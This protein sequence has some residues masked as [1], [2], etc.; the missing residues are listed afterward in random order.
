MSQ[1]KGE[2]RGKLSDFE[3]GRDWGKKF[4]GKMLA[5]GLGTIESVQQAIE[6]LAPNSDDPWLQGVLEGY[7]EVIEMFK[8]EE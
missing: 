5:Y 2:R 3:A 4:A 7:R 1:L 8:E 6:L